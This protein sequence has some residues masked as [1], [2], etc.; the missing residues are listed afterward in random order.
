MSIEMTLLIWS[1]AVAAIYIM[2]QSAFYRLDHGVIYAGSARDNERAP[3]ILN[4]RADKALRN[5]LETYGIFIAL[6]VATELTGRSGGLTQWGATIWLAMRVFYL[7]AYVSGIPFLR[8]GIWMVSAA[9]LVMMFVGVA[10]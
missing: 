8:S 2:V 1:T 3:N 4:A 10:F 9:G 7:P 5:F 6:A